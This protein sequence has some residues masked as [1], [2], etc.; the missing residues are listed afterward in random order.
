MTAGGMDPLVTLAVPVFNDEWY[1]PGALASLAAQ[2]YPNLEILVSDNASTDRTPEI[3][4]EFGAGDSRVRALRQDRNLGA[5]ENFNVLAREARG[6]YLLFCGSDDLRPPECVRRC[7]AAATAERAALVCTGVQLIGPEGESLPDHPPGLRA[8]P[9]GRTRAGRIRNLL[10]GA[11]WY[12]FYGLIHLPALR[13]TR[14]CRPV[15]GFDAVLTAELALQGPVA[16]VPDRLLHYRRFPGKSQQDM[17]RTLGASDDGGGPNVALM[18]LELLRGIAASP[19]G[20]A[21]TRMIQAVA[22]FQA[23]VRNPSLRA[24]FRGHVDAGV[25]SLQEGGDP[26]GVRTLRRLSWLAGL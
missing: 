26:D 12:D 8:S 13:R 16:H 11:F 5:I 10:R 22:A 24:D 20:G 23:L 6:D 15:W 25:R 9:V 17:A 14:L 19:P 1:L 7:V 4:Q 2:D 18:L 3:V 21:G